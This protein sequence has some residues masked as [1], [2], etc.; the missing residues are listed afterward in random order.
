MSTTPP[1]PPTDYSAP[2]AG[3]A[4][5]QVEIVKRGNGFG[6]TAI[7]LGSVAFVGSFIPFLNYGTG[8]LAFLG[9]VFGVIG[10]ILKGRRRGAAITGSI[11]SAVALILSIVLA[12]TYTAGMVNAVNDSIKSDTVKANKTITLVY[13]V[14]GDSTDSSIT[15]S[16]WNNGNSGSED[17]NNQTLPFEKTL[18]VKQGGTFDFNSYSLIASSGQTGTTISCKITLD[19]KVVSQHTASGS[20]ATATCDYTK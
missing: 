13:D 11:I 7:I 5:Y 4:P 9:L 12:I 10:L 1:V 18:T 8:F 3:P 20:F 14:T 19:G 17:A 16:T 6:I 15:Y 2:D